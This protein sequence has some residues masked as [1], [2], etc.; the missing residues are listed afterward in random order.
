LTRTRRA[1]K[2]KSQWP[3]D[4]ISFASWTRMLSL[5]DNIIYPMTIERFSD[6]HIDTCHRIW[7]QKQDKANCNIKIRLYYWLLIYVHVT[8]TN[9][10]FRSCD[11][12]ILSFSPPTFGLTARKWPRSI[13][14]ETTSLDITSTY[15]YMLYNNYQYS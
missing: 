9:W 8:K 10:W 6:T 12:I 7:K 14:F 1:T 15:S 4:F 5:F 2:H 11:R 3:M 13:I